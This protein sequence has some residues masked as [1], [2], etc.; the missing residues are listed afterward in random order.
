MVVKTDLMK[1]YNCYLTD[2]HNLQK[3]EELYNG[4][5]GGDNEVLDLLNQLYVLLE[6]RVEDSIEECYGCDNDDEYYDVE[7]VLIEDDSIDG[8]KFWPMIA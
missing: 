5:D 7:S 6:S 2:L 3:F 4:W 1:A 8:D